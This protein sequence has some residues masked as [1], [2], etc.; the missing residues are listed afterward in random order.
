MKNTIHPRLFVACAFI[1]GCMLPA[2][3]GCGGGDGGA[4]SEPPAGTAA[5]ADTE[6]TYEV[7]DESDPIATIVM[8]N[9]AVI[10]IELFPGVAPESVRNFIALADSGYYDGVI[11][12]RV[13]PGFMIQGGDPEGT[14]RGGPGYNIAGEFDNNGIANP[15][16]HVRGV[17][18]M[19]RKGDPANPA[20]F[21]DSA[22]SQFFICVGD[23]FGLDGDY[24]AFGRVV[25]GMDTADDIAKVQR[26]SSD[27]PLT[28]QKIRQVTVDT[29]GV[30]YPGPEKLPEL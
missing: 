9:G 22:G 29:K 20:R 19:A 25:Y 23:S 16:S 5:P 7:E 21:Y 10:V 1:L 2:L 6:I 17:V 14:G 18:S 28:D 11:F 24:A 8:E 3:G 15:I 27:K 12:H 13:I 26:D 30:D 4:Q